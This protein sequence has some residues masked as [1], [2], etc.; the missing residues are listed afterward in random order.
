MHTRYIVIAWGRLGVLF[1]VLAHNAIEV[2]FDRIWVVAQ[3]APPDL[4]P[5]LAEMLDLETRK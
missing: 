1:G 2:D 4:K 5:E 3:P